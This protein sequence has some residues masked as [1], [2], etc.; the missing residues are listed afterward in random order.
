MRQNRSDRDTARVAVEL[1]LAIQRL[2]ARLRKESG[3][4]LT[5]F[6]ISQLAMLQRIIEAS[7]TTAAALAEAEHVRPQSIA[8]VVVSLKAAGLV[9]AEP[10][11]QDGRK[12]LLSATPSGRRLLD[13]LIVSGEAWLTRAI[14]A[15]IGADDRSALDT[16]IGLLDR[17]ASAD[18][19]PDVAIR[20]RG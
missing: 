4:A 14:D 18:L 11:P 5:E 3:A 2:R 9:Q 10:D 12:R 1:S 17:L 8:Q 6:S 15:V 7:S 16:A 19:R 13:S 20:W